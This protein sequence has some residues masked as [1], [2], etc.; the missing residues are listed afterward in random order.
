[1]LSKRSRYAENPIEE[2]D[3]VAEALMKKGRHVIQLNR[4]DPPVYFP[5][6][7][8]IIDAYS[9]ALQEG[10]TTYSRAEGVRVLV[11]AVSKR[12]RSLYN[13]RVDEDSII[14]TQGVSEAI[15][16]INSSLIDGGDAAIILKPYYPIYV[17]SLKIFG[18]RPFV[19][20]YDENNNW[21]IDIDNL[22][23]RL[24]K[25]SATQRKRIKYIM[26]TNPNNPTGTVLSR[27]ALE[28]VVEL[29]NEHSLLL[30]SDEIYDEI[31]YN[32]A[33]FTSIGQLAKGVPHMILNGSSKIF[34][35][36]G[37]RIGF[38]IVP[39]DDKVSS[40]LKLKLSDYA[41]ARLSAN[42]PAQYAV[43]EAML[44]VKEH[45]KAIRAMVGSIESRVNYATKLIAESEF[46]SIVEPNG[47][48]YLFP[49]VDLKSMGFKNDA[50]FVNELLNQEYVQLTRGSGFG[51]PSH[52][53]IVALP[54]KD[55]LGYA[56]NK[57]N[58]FC[59]K[60]AK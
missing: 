28:N 42:T 23:R 2:E 19:G 26:I 49:R 36:T 8:Y 12:Y 41:K 44:N 15:S 6:P 59:K 38:M 32:G 11:E 5:T 58:D 17:P 9:R 18:G 51:M 24:R 50:Q 22:E 7:K 47:A 10:R 14:V 34:D 60:N 3:R 25:L 54:P 40:A 43:A 27:R 56:I 48:F 21:D 29:A 13:M 37:F 33:K 30:I 35:S 1:M 20:S 53:R 52:I 57:I 55:I 46:F 4:G 31:V 39:D 16:F 45:R